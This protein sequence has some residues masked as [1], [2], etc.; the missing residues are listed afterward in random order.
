MNTYTVVLSW[1][2]EA[3]IW[4]ASNDDIPINL[5]SE[6]V[7]KLMERVKLATPELLELNNKDTR[8]T[9]HFIAEREEEVA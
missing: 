9:L 8:C 1:D 6:S 3:A 2:S 5:E 4:R 7:D